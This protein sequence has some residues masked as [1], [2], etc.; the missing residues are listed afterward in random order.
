MLFFSFLQNSAVPPQ[1][2][3]LEEWLIARA[4]LRN[5]LKVCCFSLLPRIAWFPHD[6]NTSQVRLERFKTIW[7]CRNLCSIGAAGELFASHNVQC[8]TKAQGDVAKLLLRTIR[9]W[10]TFELSPPAGADM[11]R[12]WV[13]R[14][15]CTCEQH[16]VV[17]DS[18]CCTAADTSDTCCA[19]VHASVQWLA[20]ADTPLAS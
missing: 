11:A 6:A 15:C 19:L 9:R 4:E 7:K 13:A 12:A 10:A 16:H 3:P 2:D 5:M 17:F 18:S 1:S 14:H 20:A 8:R